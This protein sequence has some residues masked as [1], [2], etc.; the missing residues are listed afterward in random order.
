MAAAHKVM[1]RIDRGSPCELCPILDKVACLNVLVLRLINTDN[2][3]FLRMLLPNAKLAAGNL[4]QGVD[5]NNIKHKNVMST[6]LQ[7]K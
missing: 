4:Q 6:V 5:R 1:V 2:S 7:I 3:D